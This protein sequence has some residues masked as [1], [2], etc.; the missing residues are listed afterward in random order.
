MF[1]RTTRF[2]FRGT[3]FRMRKFR[4][5][6]ATPCPEDA[7]GDVIKLRRIYDISRG[8]SAQ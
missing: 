2:P 7:F 1:L 8:S 4:E 5:I 6:R 3:R